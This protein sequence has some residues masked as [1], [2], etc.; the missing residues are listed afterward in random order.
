MSRLLCI[1][2]NYRTA[3][4]TLRAAE[5]LL[6]DIAELDAELVIVDNASGDGS[7]ARIE[8][9]VAAN[10]WAK[11]GRVRV[12]GSPENGGFGAGNNIG[13]QAGMSDGSAPDFVYLLNSDAF[14]DRGCVA[15]LLDHFA[16]HPNAGIA[17]SHVRGEDGIDH[18]TA[19]R[20]PSI[21]GE[22]E[23][24][25]RLG[26]ITRALKNAVVPMGV[27]QT[28]TRLDW[29]AGASMMLRCDMLYEIGGF[30]ETFFLYFEETDLCLRA[31]RAGWETWYI[32]ES[33]VVHIGSVSTGMKTKSRMPG[34]W[35]DSRRYYFTKNHGAI[36]GTLALAARTTGGALHQLRSKLSGRPSQDPPRF[37]RDLMAHALRPAPKMQ[38]TPR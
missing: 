31:A 38:E 23:G 32:P 28:A 10:G 4:M 16:H 34:Y 5:A 21:L 24:A 8:Q 27:P 2:L 15:A 30:D 1:I 3:E 29:T 25:A 35:F 17:G 26:F 12:I 9:A 7:L 36:Y 20:F 18:C 22:F 37:L 33:R 19:F 11:N 13:I 6:A 14:P